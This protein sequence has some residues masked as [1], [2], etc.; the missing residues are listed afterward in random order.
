MLPYYLIY[1][2][3]VY[4]ESL[5]SNNRLYTLKDKANTDGLAGGCLSSAALS[6]LL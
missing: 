5:H 1:V 2:S 6:R 4:I 3:L